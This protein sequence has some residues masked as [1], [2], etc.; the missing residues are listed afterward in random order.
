LENV[1]SRIQTR[2]VLSHQLT[3][4]NLTISNLA[5]SSLSEINYL[6]VIIKKVFK[7]YKRSIIKVLDE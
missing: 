2:D 1:N 3:H 4:H 5:T 6:Y 7:L